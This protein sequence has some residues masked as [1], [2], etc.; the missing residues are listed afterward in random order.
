MEGA[1]DE[2]ADNAQGSGLAP[3]PYVRVWDLP[4]RLTHWSFA[5]LVPALWWSA[6]NSQWALHKRF[7]VALLGL[8]AL[9]G[10]AEDARKED[11]LLVLPGGQ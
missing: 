10:V 8:L 6:E 9:G 1:A 7:G 11:L 2:A 5:F 4:L 3:D